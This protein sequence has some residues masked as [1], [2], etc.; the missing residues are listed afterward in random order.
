MYNVYVGLPYVGFPRTCPLFEPLSGR[1]G[2]FPE[3]WVLSGFSAFVTTIDA[4]LLLFRV[5]NIII[6]TS[7]FL[8]CDCLPACLPASGTL[9]NN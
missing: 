3:I 9:L 6:N 7:V 8:I 5:I 4:F 1:P 2:G